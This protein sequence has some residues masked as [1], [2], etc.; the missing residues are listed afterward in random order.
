MQIQ[1]PILT[2]SLLISNRPD[3][4]PR[5]LDSLKG[6]MEAI[7]SELILIDTSKSPEV[8]KLLLKYTDKVYEFEWCNDFA[9]ARN[10]GL[11]RAKGEWFLFLDDDEWFVETEDIIQF[12]QSG[13]YKQYGYANYQVRNFMNIDYTKYHDAWVTRM[14]C[15]EKDTEFKGKVHE[16]FCPIRGQLKYLNS[17]ANHS[18]YIFLDEVQKRK[19]FERNTEILLNMVEEEP[20]E[21]RW[22]AQLVQEY[23][24]IREWQTMVSFCKKQLEQ[25]KEVN[26]TYDRNHFS[27]L[28]AGMMAGLTALGHHEESIMVARKALEDKR[29]IELLKALSYFRMAENHMNLGEWNKAYTCANAYLE[30]YKVLSKN[31]ELMREQSYS[32]LVQF[33]FEKVNL[34]IG[35][36]IL[37]Y[38]DLKKGSTKAIREHYEELG[39]NQDDLYV[40]EKLPLLLIECMS[41]MKYEPI[42]A[43]AIT[44]ACKDDEFRNFICG[45]AQ[46][47]EQKDEAAFEKIA[48][49]F[50]QADAD[51]WFIWYTRMVVANAKNDKSA[52]ESALEGFV[53]SVPNVFH[54]P[55][56]V[57]EL[58]QKKDIQVALIWAKVLED[59][60]QVQVKYFVNNHDSKQVDIVRK[61]LNKT[62]TAE[63]WQLVSFE[64]AV[65]E[66][67]IEEGPKE[68]WNLSS[69]YD[70]LKNYAIVSI[71]YFN[72]FC[73]QS[74]QE[75][76]EEV[77]AAV[78]IKEYIDVE[79]QDK[80]Q[81]LN[82]LKDAVEIYPKFADGIGKFLHSYPEL[83]RQRARKQKVE[84]CQ[85]RDQVME[86]V[87]VMAASGQE[88]AAMQIMQQLK[89]MFPE[90]LEVIALGLEL[91]LQTLE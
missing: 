85:L 84:M 66:K 19:H 68:P 61:F 28:Y 47:W 65:M 24:S 56:K 1:K 10:E 43:K 82:N 16:I 25:V 23:N 35:H 18:G 60:W 58:I 67:H 5:C 77:M 6:I 52:L 45:E 90:D 63:D 55:E 12:F 53:K 78:K 33:A 22:K 2:I 64:L 48:Y 13:E 40:Y 31:Q 54:L 49:A 7:P 34:K 4:I 3:T 75:I 72:S 73:R 86:Q 38:C 21:L 57:Y 44:D 36:S 87:K 9:K 14:F 46:Q 30:T 15:I 32:L 37:A 62:F 11:K 41:T 39:W 29:G 26:T 51:F 71:G 76:P 83:E 42:F 59:D 88:Q 80:I 50:A 8:H 27:T 74:A 69:Y 91:R 20:E 81:A 89:Q 17:L 70:V 79:S